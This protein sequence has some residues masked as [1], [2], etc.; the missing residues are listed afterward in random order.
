[1]RALSSYRTTKGKLAFALPKSSVRSVSI[2]KTLEK[3][4]MRP[5]N[6]YFVPGNKRLPKVDFPFKIEPS[7]EEGQDLTQE[8]QKIFQM[9]RRGIISYSEEV[10]AYLRHEN[11]FVAAHA[12]NHLLDRLRIDMDASKV[13]LEEMIERLEGDK[14]VLWS[15]HTDA[16]AKRYGYRA[17]SRKSHI[18]KYLHPVGAWIRDEASADDINKLLDAFGSEP[19]F[20]T[21]AANVTK[22][23]EKLMVRLASDWRLARILTQNPAL[24]KEWIDWSLKE[25][26][27]VFKPGKK[28]KL[29]GRMS[30]E[31]YRPG[32]AFGLWNLMASRGGYLSKEDLAHVWDYYKR[33]KP[34][35]IDKYNIT[36]ALLVNPHLTEAQLEE[37]AKSERFEE[38]VAPLLMRHPNM[39]E[40]LMEKLWFQ[41][42]GHRIREEIL[43]N[44][45]DKFKNMVRD[46]VLMDRRLGVQTEYISSLSGDEFTHYMTE[47]LGQA[48]AFAA[49]ILVKI[50]IKEPLAVDEEVMQRLL[51][52]ADRDVR[53]HTLDLMG[54]ELLQIKKQGIEGNKKRI[55][56]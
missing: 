8:Y 49:K 14:D 1:M 6:D 30:G 44:A 48:P 25:S 9:T 5:K 46:E 12:V 26:V 3:I 11:L 20:Y 32:E 42:E 19:F 40:K 15:V 35:G 21:I 17:F 24:P 38:Q 45:G 13:A 16:V 36:R 10:E 56:R 33:T 7:K 43:K 28:T 54:K 41:K 52:S 2:T 31:S 39:T 55:K 37:L 50:E 22:F 23:N 27:K 29:V 53:I 47:L 4:P 34:A 51:S 18:K